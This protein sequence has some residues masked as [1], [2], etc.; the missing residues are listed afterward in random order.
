[1]PTFGTRRPHY[2]GWAKLERTPRIVASFDVLDSGHYTTG[3]GGIATVTS[4]QGR[5]VV[6]S[7]S[8]TS[9]RPDL[10]SAEINGK[11]VLSFAA[12]DF[13]TVDGLST[14][15]AGVPGIFSRGVVQLSAYP[16]SLYCLDVI[17]SS[18]GSGL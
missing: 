4:Q 18:T 9:L 15:F 2:L 13:F 10:A 16:A 8:N 17:F 14:A 11:D 3:T 12:G 7:Q 6:G 5:A 1:V